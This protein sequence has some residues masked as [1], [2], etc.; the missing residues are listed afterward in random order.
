MHKFYSTN[1]YHLLY[2]KLTFWYWLQKEI[3]NLCCFVSKSLWSWHSTYI[4]SRFLFFFQDMIVWPVLSLTQRI[5]GTVTCIPAPSTH[6]GGI[7]AEKQHSLGHV[8]VQPLFQQNRLANTQLD[9][10]RYRTRWSNTTIT[11]N[12]ATAAVSPCLPL[13]Q[14]EL[15]RNSFG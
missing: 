8:C 11:E 3:Q 7:P 1:I 9:K 14:E 13:S 15:T 2:H 10:D 12:N 6:W 5:S 4:H